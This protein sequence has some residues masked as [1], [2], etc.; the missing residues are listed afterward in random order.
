MDHIER[1]CNI[2]SESKMVWYLLR[3][4][5]N[6]ASSAGSIAQYH[7]SLCRKLVQWTSSRVNNYGYETKI[8]REEIYFRAY[9]SVPFFTGFVEC[10]EQ[11]LQQQNKKLTIPTSA[12]QIQRQIS[13]CW[14][15]A[16]HQMMW[17]LVA[18]NSENHL[19]HLVLYILI[20][21]N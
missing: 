10:E 1:L 19:V 16:A 20:N 12:S 8:T 13:G 15:L 18:E 17:R 9:R 4:M 5:E 6:I 2:L 11:V 7:F 21:F 14:F 3:N